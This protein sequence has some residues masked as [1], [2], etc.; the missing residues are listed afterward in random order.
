[1]KPVIMMIGAALVYASTAA[2]AEPIVG[3]WKTE[4]GETAEISACGKAYCINL[5][6]GEYAGKQIGKVEGA[7]ADYTGVVTDPSDD[8]TYSGSA[9]INGDWLK[10]KGCVLSIFCK[11]QTWRR[12]Q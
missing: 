4:H 5:K 12:M 11:S 8:K 7:S 2:A 1:M 9:K 10:L 6:T 3:K